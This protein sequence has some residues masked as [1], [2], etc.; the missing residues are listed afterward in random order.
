MLAL[1]QAVLGGDANSQVLFMP[2]ECLRGNARTCPFYFR[3]RELIL[4]E[5]FPKMVNL[6]T[7]EDDLEDAVPAGI[8]LAKRRLDAFFGSRLALLE[9]ASEAQA[10][11][12]DHQAR[13]QDHQARHQRASER[14]LASEHGAGRYGDTREC[15]E[16]KQQRLSSPHSPLG[17][18]LAP[19]GHFDHWLTSYFPHFSSREAAEA[20]QSAGCDAGWFR[21]VY[22]GRGDAT[23]EN[24]GRRRCIMNAAE[25][26]DMLDAAACLLGQGDRGKRGKCGHCVH[27]NSELNTH[28][29]LETVALVRSAQLLVGVQGSQ[30]FNLLFASDSAVFVEIV[31]FLRGQVC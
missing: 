15:S 6:L 28:T 1:I 21:A 29:F 11:H 17:R 7:T 22:L 18:A 8:R 20:G 4:V 14:L 30:N 27:V 24:G 3:P 31:P 5:M 23:C 26:V 25:V 13:H 16:A 19:C 12:Q 9:R 10:R 2:T